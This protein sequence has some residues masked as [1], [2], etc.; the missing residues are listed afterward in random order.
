MGLVRGK[1]DEAH[2]L[3]QELAGVTGE[4]LTEAVTTALRD[5][6]SAPAPSPHRFRHPRL[7]PGAEEDLM[8]AGDHLLDIALSHHEREVGARSAL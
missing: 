5:R 4:S 7:R 2:R 6:L 8:Q 1:Y 3:A